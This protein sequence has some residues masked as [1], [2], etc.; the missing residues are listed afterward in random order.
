MTTALMVLGIAVFAFA[1]VGVLVMPGALARL[2]YASVAMLGVVLVAAAV[3]VH[4]G[5]ALLSVKPLVVPAFMATT[6]PMLAHAT[7]RALHAREE[8]RR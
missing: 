4:G 1:C 3:V 2:H 7:A 6:S 8:R 5:A